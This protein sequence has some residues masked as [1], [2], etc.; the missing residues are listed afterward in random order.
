MPVR[1]FHAGPLFSIAINAARSIEA[2]LR[3]GGQEPALV[4]IVFSAVSLEAFMNEITGAAQDTLHDPPDLNPPQLAIFAEVMADAEDSHARLESKFTLAKWILGGARLE[5]GAAQYQDFTLLMQ[6]RN[7][8]VH[9]KANDAFDQSASPEEI[10]K[11]L[12][13][14]YGNKHILAE[15]LQ[16]SQGWEYLIET[17]AAANWS[18][19]T[20]ANIVSDLCQSAVQSS[21]KAVFDLVNGSFQS[22]CAML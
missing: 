20:A 16:Y 21:I 6:L 7:D 19:R 3:T 2:P 14:K 11:R 17:K 13:S 8:I 9:F 22:G 15:D 4:S 10:H 18:C 1:Y 12:F 5:R